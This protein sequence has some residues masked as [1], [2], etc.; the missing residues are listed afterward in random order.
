MAKTHVDPNDEEL[1]GG[2]DRLLGEYSHNLSAALRGMLDVEAGLRDILLHSR[3]DDLVEGLGAILDLEAGLADIVGTDADASQQRQ[4]PEKRRKHGPKPAAVAEQYLRTVGPEIRLTLRVNPDVAA[5]ALTFEGAHRLLSSLMQV[6]DYAY[7]LKADLQQHLAFA[8]Y[9]ELESAHEQAIEIIG[10]L[11]HTDASRAAR[12]LARGLAIG[13]TDDLESA[14]T[15]AEAFLQ[16]APH[17]TGLAEIRELTDALSRAAIRNCA[18]SRRLLRL[19]AEEVRGAISTVL[20]RDLPLLDEDSISVFLD[21]F[22]TSDLRAADVL[23][24]VLDGIR[25]SEHGTLWPAAFNVEALKAQSDE[26]PPGS[27]THI[28]RRGTAPMHNT[29]AGLA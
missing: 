15:T 20:G 12:D 18:R 28:V 14:R 4:R 6:K 26:T 13:L 23:G 22:T 16:H 9:S 27:G 1:D 5:A 25:W 19:C 24:V 11:A 17:F 10:D 21:D 8:V 2:V 3:H 29:Y 7:T